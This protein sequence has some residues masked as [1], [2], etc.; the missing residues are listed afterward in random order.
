ML[1]AKFAGSLM[2]I[3]VLAS[4][5]GGLGTAILYVIRPT[6]GKLAV[7][8]PFSLAAIFAAVSSAAGGG[9]EVL[10]GLAFSGPNPNMSNV[11]MGW[12]ETLLPVYVSFG[13]LSLAWLLVAVGLRRA[14]SRPL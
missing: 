3:A 10:Q 7:L 9:A 5:I 14:E 12:A 1:I 2:W 4:G 8:R 11:L 13:F 6:E